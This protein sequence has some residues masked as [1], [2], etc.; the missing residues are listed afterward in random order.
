MYHQVYRSEI[1]CS[2]HTVFMYFVWISEQTAIFSLY[3]IN[4]SVFITQAESVYC[5]VRTGALN[6][7]E[8]V[9]S[10]KG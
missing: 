1:L 3:G 10:L 6:Q 8:T 5:A 9:S 4:L 2:A 7:T